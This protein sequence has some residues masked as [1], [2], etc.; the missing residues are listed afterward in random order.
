MNSRQLLLPDSIKEPTTHAV[1]TPR[2]TYV[3][4]Q[5]RPNAVSEVDENGDVLV[6]FTDVNGD[7]LVIFTDVRWPHTCPQ[8]VTVTCWS[9][10]GTIITFYC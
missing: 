6:T 8:T 7:V 2:G 4:G 3:V 10:T 5:A 1:E 9:P